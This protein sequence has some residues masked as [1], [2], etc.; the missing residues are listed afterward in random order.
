MKFQTLACVSLFALLSAGC[1]VRDCG[2][3][4]AYLKTTPVGA[5]V[6]PDGVN[7]APPS[8]AYAIPRGGEGE[9]VLGEDYIDSKGDK[10][11]ACLYEPP[12]LQQPEEPVEPAAPEDAA[13]DQG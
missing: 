5:F 1:S 2:D 9:V 8:P 7:L 13:N 4:A 12:R 6:V 10:R 11:R 3:G